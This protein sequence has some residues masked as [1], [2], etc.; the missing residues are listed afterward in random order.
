M[1]DY[2]TV[3]EMVEVPVYLVDSGSHT[4]SLMVAT[5]YQRPHSTPQLVLTRETLMP[6]ATDATVIYTLIS[7]D[8]L[9]DWKKSLEE[10]DLMIWNPVPAHISGPKMSLEL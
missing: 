1:P 4:R 8:T 6:N 5:I 2:G 3:L 7:G 9:E 10:M